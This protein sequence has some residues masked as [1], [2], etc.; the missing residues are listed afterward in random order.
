MDCCK[1]SCG[2]PANIHTGGKITPSC[3]ARNLPWLKPYKDA[4]VCWNQAPWLDDANPMVSYG[5]VATPSAAASCGKCFEFEYLGEA[6]FRSDDAGSQRLR[7]KRMI[8]AATNIGSDVFHGQFDLMMPG[9]GVGLYDKCSN[10]FAAHQRGLDMGARYG[11]FLARCQGCNNDGGDC[12]R[13]DRA[14]MYGRT[15]SEIYEETRECVRGMCN[16]AFGDDVHYATLNAS[17]HWFVDWYEVADNPKMRYRE[18]HCPS[19]ITNRLRLDESMQTH[20]VAERARWGHDAI[21]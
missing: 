2:W 15:P 6:Q 3:D 14:K 5:F 7:G 9:G 17:C 10:Q 8:V 13:L 12:E 19:S 4:F 20:V 18:V 21:S 1:P 11:G 16:A